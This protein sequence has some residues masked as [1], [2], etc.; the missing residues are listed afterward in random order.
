MAFTLLASP[1]YGLA[2]TASAELLLAGAASGVRLGLVSDLMSIATNVLFTALV[3]AYATTNSGSRLSL[4][5]SMITYKPPRIFVIAAMLLFAISI[6]FSLLA[7]VAI[8]VIGLLGSALPL[9]FIEGLPPFRALG[10]SVKRTSQYFLSIFGFNFLV[11]APLFLILLVLTGVFNDV[12]SGSPLR[13]VSLG[14]LYG[15]GIAA[16]IYAQSA[17]YRELAFIEAE[18]REGR[19]Q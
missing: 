2:Y 18:T 15:F 17:I 12:L 13:T 11:S 9:S 10:E 7:L 5:F 16:L 6:G 19:L 3:Y 14:T 8:A 4:A 1:L